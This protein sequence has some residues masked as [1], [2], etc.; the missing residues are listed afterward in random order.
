MR[1]NVA[2]WGKDAKDLIYE[3]IATAHLQPDMFV[4]RFHDAK[5]LIYEGIA[6]YKCLLCPYVHMTSR[7]A[8]DLIYE[9]IATTCYW[10]EFV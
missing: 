3:G 2:L 4:P 5:D 9:G 7:D 1:N 6:T 10:P 8:K